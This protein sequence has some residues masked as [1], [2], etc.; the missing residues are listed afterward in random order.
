MQH[1]RPMG[2]EKCQEMRLTKKRDD[3]QFCRLHQVYFTE[4]QVRNIRQPQVS[5]SIT[6]SGV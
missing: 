6:G 4:T 2:A 1:T 3:V 5:I